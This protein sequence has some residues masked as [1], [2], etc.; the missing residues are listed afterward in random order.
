V[1]KLHLSDDVAIDA[2]T[3]QTGVFAMLGIR[4]SGKT[5]TGAV[6]AEQFWDAKLRF[7]VLDPL[8]VWWG[9]RLKKDGET[10]S[11]RKVTIFGGDRGDL[12]LDEG[13]AEKIADLVVDGVSAILDLSALSKSAQDRFVG[14]FARRLFQKNREALHVFIDEADAFAP[15]KLRGAGD[16]S[17]TTLG[18]IEDLVRRGRS[19]GIG[20]SL[21]TQRPAVLNKNVLT[22]AGTLVLHRVTSPQDRAA[23]IEWAKATA[24][25]ARI[26]EI[27]AS[28][29]TFRP[30]DA[31]VWS[32]SDFDL[33]AKTRIH[34]ADGYESSRTPKAGESRSIPK[35]LD[36]IDTS[37]LRE[38]LKDAVARF[39]D[40][41]AKALKRRLVEAQ[42]ELAK[43]KAA[44]AAKPK[45]ERVKTPAFSDRQVKRL[46]V[47]FAK[48]V[49][50]AERHGKAMAMFW[51]NQ[52]EVATALLGAIRS[53]AGWAAPVLPL[54]SP[55]APQPSQPPR[56]APRGDSRESHS[57][58]IQ[59]SGD[60]ELSPSQRKAID[61]FAML[62]ARAI[63]PSPDSV[64]RWLN[65]HPRGGSY[66][67]TLAF[68]RAE[69]YLDGW[70]LTERGAAESR[71]MPTGVD[72]VIA[73]L[74][75]PSWR[76]AFQ[77][78]DK[79]GPLSS[80][81]LAANLNVHPRGGSYLRTL[82]RLRAM[83]VIT[84]RGP[85]ALTE[86]ARR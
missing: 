43:L 2:Q 9:I 62:A 49:A 15:Q 40:T 56:P 27:S 4:G 80:E 32:P 18:A 39:E 5:N 72:G 45:V 28:V 35:S 48:V 3:A 26:E 31:W 50:E 42:A 13:S 46:E 10:P 66:L 74:P 67:R 70:T 83:G 7:V 25:P 29:A 6:M 17:A 30:G 22:Q 85:I 63:Q 64:A 71:P 53:V 59:S 16:D 81:E 68:L 61:V 52:D 75:S 38:Q 44:P 65:V 79:L 84:E 60:G 76:D 34:L 54:R 8:G 69:G 36:E 57:R 20:L 55:G 21:I 33:L 11:G 41:D 14:K 12:P 23:F 47:L 77:R 58:A 1:K 82:A 24:D 19:H 86:G 37:A 78:I 73:A 51:E